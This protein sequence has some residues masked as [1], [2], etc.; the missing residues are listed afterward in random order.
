MRTVFRGLA[1]TLPAGSAMLM[2]AACSSATAPTAPEAKAATM[3][4]QTRVPSSSGIIRGLVVDPANRPVANAVVECMSDAQCTLFADVSAQDG[5]DQGVK[6]NANGFYELKVSRS[7]GGGFFLSASALGYEIQ[8][9]EVRLPDSA[10][11]WDQPKCAI[12]VNFTL[13]PAG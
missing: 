12:T 9:Q 11:T 3:A 10:C 8:R 5:P 2:L 4:T 7:G 1:R 13:T 6:T